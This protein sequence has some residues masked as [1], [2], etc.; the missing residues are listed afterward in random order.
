MINKGMIKVN[1]D[2]LLIKYIMAAGYESL[3]PEWNKI[4]LLYRTFKREDKLFF[5]EIIE[6]AITVEETV[7]NPIN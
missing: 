6:E 3:A 7:E 4:S 1:D 2:L 5:C